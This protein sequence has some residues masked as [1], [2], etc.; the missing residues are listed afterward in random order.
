MAAACNA[1][2][3]NIISTTLNNTC[4]LNSGSS[5]VVTSPEGLIDVV[6]KYGVKISVGS[7]LPVSSINNQGT[8]RS[9]GANGS[10]GMGIYMESNSSSLTAVTN[11]TNSGTISGT[12]TYLGLGI[13]V[14]G[15]VLGSLN[16]S[17]TISGQG[18]AGE[19][20]YLNGTIGSIVNSGIISG[21]TAAI[22]VHSGGVTD[23]ISNTGTLD[24]QVHL[25][26][27]TLNLNG[28]HAVVTGAVHGGAA[29]VVNVNGT[30]TSGDTFDVG[31]LKVAS[32][33]GV[34]NLGHDVKTKLGVHN[35]GKLAVAAGTSVMIFGNYTQSA[36][37]VFETG[38]SSATSYGQLVVS[39]TADLSASNKINV[40]VVGAP[41]LIAG[42][43]AQPGVITAET[44]VAGPSFTVTDNSALFDFIAT[45]NG[46]AVDLCVET[47]GAS[48]CT[49]PDIVVP[50]VVVPP[51][52]VPPV[53]VPPVV[54]PPVVVPPTAIVP[55]I[56][57]VKPKITVVSSVQNNQNSSTIG[58]AT[59]FDQLIAQGSQAPSSMQSI[60]TALGTLPT[61]LAVSNAVRQMVPL[62]NGGM[63]EINS[64]VLHSI[65]RVVQ[66][67]QDA[68]KGRSSGD[69]FINNQEA[70][71]KPMGSWAN[72]DDSNGVSGYKAD[73]Y[74]LVLGADRLITDQVRLGGALSYLRSKV[75]SNSS[76]AP[77]SAQVDGYRGIVYGSYS[78]DPRTDVNFQAALGRSHT[79][80]DRAINF[81]GLNHVASSSYNSWNAHLG[82]GIARSFNMAEKTTLTP[83]LR[84]DYMYIH[85]A[86][87]TETGA[88]ALSLNVND[89]SAQ[90][91]TF[92]MD[93]KLNHAINE[94]VI[95]TA[96]L[97]GGYDTLSQQSSISSAFVGG[98]AQFI[99]KGLDPSPWFARG[100][101]GLMITNSKA[102]EITARY[103][104]EARNDFVNQTASI[105][106]RMP[107]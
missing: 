2:D 78:L 83:S 68:N 29:S 38:L 25:N 58:V 45:K 84:A 73:S 86:A 8:I 52:V 49:A 37:G 47:A 104:V 9:L 98:G 18:N 39:G 50:P 82:A 90:E 26:T 14:N 60:I 44:L 96:N 93:S 76:V 51:V 46:N 4:T 57:D 94:Q 15:S 36:T 79:E 69:E 77:Q 65:D 43:S 54:V 31:T 6:G 30:F 88:G 24:G 70:W 95:F 28:D 63:A 85:D 105:K 74:G 41:S 40:N 3:S 67:R 89:N 17:G 13:A 48:R 22:Y 27:S 87:Y 106:L 5:L 80:G 62:Q 55:P 1:S 11:V 23:G 81:G 19:G 32:S 56:P 91:L 71:L 35:S 53:V 64:S 97:G 72:Q 33:D 20:V 42:T 12:G 59:V 16:N 102:L 75:D 7:G 101:L 21:S 66:A 103:D 100:G 34:L 10:P 92:S 107:F 99:T 61:E